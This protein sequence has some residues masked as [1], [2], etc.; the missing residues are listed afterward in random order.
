MKHD[1]TLHNVLKIV[2][3][4]ETASNRWLPEARERWGKGKL[5]FNGY[6]VSVLQYEKIAKQYA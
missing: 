3:I 6:R 1:N 5:L 4:T 2:K